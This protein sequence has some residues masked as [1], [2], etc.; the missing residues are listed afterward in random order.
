ML[1]Y[2]LLLATL[3]GVWGAMAFDGIAYPTV[4]RNLEDQWRTFAGRPPVLW[5]VSSVRPRQPFMIRMLW[6]G[7]SVVDGKSAIDCNITIYDPAGEIFF[8]TGAAPLE[9]VTVACSNPRMFFVYPRIV[10]VVFP[11]TAAPGQYRIEVKLVDANNGDEKVLNSSIELRTA[12]AEAK[13]F[14]SVDDL[15][16]WVMG[17]YSHPEPDQL[18]PAL[19]KFISSF[20][21]LKKKPFSPM[22]MLC[23]FYHTFKENP[24]LHAALADYVNTLEG[25]GLNAAALVAMQLGGEAVGRL[26]AE[27]RRAVPA[28]GG[29]PFAVAAPETPWHLDMLWSEFFATGQVAPVGKLVELL[30]NLQY[31]ITPD[32]YKQKKEPTEQDKRNLNTYMLGSA[33]Q[34]SLKANANA[35]R[36]VFCYLEGILKRDR[37]ADAGTRQELAG[38][39]AAV[40]ER[41]QQQ[42][43]Q[44]AGQAGSG[45]AA[46]TAV[47]EGK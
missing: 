2:C 35:H 5:T 3:L 13:E 32:E 42:P 30:R 36:L 46:G 4:S 19:R 43:R 8:C 1:K 47:K 39:V 38:I 27:A 20:P 24:Q 37:V 14:A 40:G 26:S 28:G 17:Y 12:P 15:S 16:K 21:E 34:W 25:A 7:A 9:R 33:A 10:N 11:E 31:G 44:D 23:F 22:P 45:A 18:I 6:S 29:N 41:W